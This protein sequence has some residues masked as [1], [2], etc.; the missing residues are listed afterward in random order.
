[1]DNVSGNLN[2]VAVLNTY[3][4]K[5]LSQAYVFKDF[6]NGSMANY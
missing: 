1:M 3:L 5:T 4:T 2:I 6:N